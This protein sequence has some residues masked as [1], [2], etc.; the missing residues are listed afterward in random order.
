MG[1]CTSRP[2]DNTSFSRD[3][4]KAAE[5]KKKIALP[6]L[7]VG[8]EEFAPLSGLENTTT[9]SSAY[10]FCDSWHNSSLQSR[11][12]ASR[13]RSASRN[14]LQSDMKEREERGECIWA[15]NS[16]PLSKREGPVI[17]TMSARE[18]ENSKEQIE[19][20]NQYIFLRSIGDGSTGTVKLVINEDDEKLYAIKILS[21]QSMRKRISISKS[22]SRKDYS[23]VDGLER[24]IAIL[25]K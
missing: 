4:S 17:E 24:E 8:L 11:S 23:V 20:V 19:F 6:V 12:R 1:S 9:R 14:Q 2:L 21:R 5:N 15:K 7:D 18:E 13:A 16:L 10:T 25:K 22:P 3:T